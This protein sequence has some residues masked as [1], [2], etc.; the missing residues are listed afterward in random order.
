M[1]EEEWLGELS[2]KPKLV[3]LWLLKENGCESWYLDVASKS[4]RRVMMMLR[5]GTAPS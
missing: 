1:I 2:T 4:H 5:G 3:I